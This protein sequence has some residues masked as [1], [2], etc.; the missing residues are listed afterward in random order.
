MLLNSHLSFSLTT[1]LPAT[2][3]TTRLDGRRRSPPDYFTIACRYLEQY[4]RLTQRMAK[5]Q[6]HLY[7]PHARRYFQDTLQMIRQ[8]S[9]TEAALLKAYGAPQPGVPPPGPDAWTRRYDLDPQWSGFRKW[10]RENYGE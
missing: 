10:F 6:P 8:E 7:G 4:V 5:E 3:L 2:Y 9:E 1:N